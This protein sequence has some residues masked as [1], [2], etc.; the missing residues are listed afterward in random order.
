[1]FRRIVAGLLALPAAIAS[2]QDTFLQ[3]WDGGSFSYPA[4]QPEIT[5]Q[6]L[7]LDGSKP[8]P[9]HCHPVPTMAH[10]LHG[11]LEV[12]TRSGQKKVFRPG[13]SLV[14]VMGTV[15]RGIVLTA[16]VELIVF[17]AGAA[18]TPNTVLADDDSSGNYCRI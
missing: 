13:D 1:M 15:H 7:T 16:P 11:E 3:S 5:A 12:E 6:T 2:A 9:F 4:G 17:Y 8:I 10:V 18:G 14:E